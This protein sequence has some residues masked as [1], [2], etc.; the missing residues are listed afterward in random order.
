MEYINNEL[1]HYGLK[2][3]KWGQRRWQNED[4]TFNEAGKRRYFGE[5]SSHRPPS[6]I[7]LQKDSDIKDKRA[8]VKEA[9]KTVKEKQKQLR[10]AHRVYNKETAG[11]LKPNEESYN[12]Y[13]ASS[14]E[15][16]KAKNQVRYAKEDFKNEIAKKSM[17]SGKKTKRQVKL[18]EYYRNKGM[19][20]EEA[21]LNAYKR[22]RVEKALMIAGGVAAT[23]AVAYA[24]KNY[25]DIHVD[26]YIK[27]G[28][29][30]TGIT[31]SSVAGVKDGYFYAAFKNNPLDRAKYTGYYA[32]FQKGGLGPTK[33]YEKVMSLP[34]GVK[35]AS[36]KSATSVLSELYNT[37]STF[38]TALKGEIRRFPTAT[39]AQK[40][41]FNKAADALAKGKIDRNVYRAFNLTLADRGQLGSMLVNNG[42]FTTTRVDWTTQ[43]KKFSDLLQKKGFGAIMDI[44]DRRYSG[45]AAR[46]PIIVFNAL[47]NAKVDSVKQLSKARI[48]A[49]ALPAYMDIMVKSIPKNPVYATY[50]AGF[51]GIKV[52]SI[53][54]TNKRNDKVV[55]E[56]RKEHPNSDLTYQQIVRN[57]E[58][59]LVS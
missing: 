38:Q 24:V 8:A 47:Q 17:N 23:V 56:Y 50:I 39:P 9:E 48:V 31:E 44:N 59:S 40:R 16:V 53:V 30:L 22:D 54:S 14:K 58:R 19:T 52:A 18:E 21:A 1:Y 7:D 32:A 6:V 4:G 55:A 28:T 12:K 34:N 11:G 29:K 45:Y 37:D 42:P 49:D 15:V 27:A 20:E 57:Y 26:R 3:M 2:G 43:T 36:E 10:T 5:T 33:L 51:G 35:M 41:L 46:N 13:L 25:R